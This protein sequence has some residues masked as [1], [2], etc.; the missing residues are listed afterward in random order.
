MVPI[1][2]LYII[3]AERNIIY[4][5]FYSA[6]SIYNKYSILDYSYSIYNINNEIA[7]TTLIIYSYYTIINTSSEV[8]YINSITLIL[9]PEINNNNI[10]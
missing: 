3:I 5:C 1:I 2:L 8:L 10:H 4:Y 9:Y 6:Y 7:V